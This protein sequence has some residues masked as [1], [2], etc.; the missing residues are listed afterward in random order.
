MPSK[1]V[2]FL[3]S[4]CAAVLSGCGGSSPLPS[5]VVTDIQ[6]NQLKYG[7]TTQFTI[8]GNLLDNEINVSVK[9]CKGLALVAGGTSTSKSVSCTIVNAGRNFPTLAGR[10]VPHP[11][12]FWAVSPALK[13]GT[14][15]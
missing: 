12:E 11:W 10:I 7:Q 5:A 2:L 1:F 3:I 14:P 13:T 4:L 6:A 15:F 8:T 9:N